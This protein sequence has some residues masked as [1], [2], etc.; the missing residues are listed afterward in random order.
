MFILVFEELFIRYVIKYFFM[1]F[2]LSTSSWE[3]FNFLKVV[4]CIRF[5]LYGFCFTFC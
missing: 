1:V 4:E 3:E 2:H 5:C